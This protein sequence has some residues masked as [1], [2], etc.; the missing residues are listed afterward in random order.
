MAGCHLRLWRY[1]RGRLRPVLGAG[2]AP[3]PRVDVDENGVVT[4]AEPGRWLARVSDTGGYWYEIVDAEGDPAEAA[5]TLAPLLASLL[6]RERDT[7]RL[8]K[9]LASRYEEIE[10]LYTISET[11]GRTIRLEEAAQTI[12]SDVSDVVGARRASIFVHDEEGA[13]LRAVAAL[14]KDVDLLHD[15]SVAR[16]QFSFS[17]SPSRRGS[18]CM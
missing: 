16:P 11:L 4:P 10:L 2:D 7:L 6:D 8:A 3:A 12:L 17:S 13:I 9:Q 18:T 1:G 14:G 5:E 15:L